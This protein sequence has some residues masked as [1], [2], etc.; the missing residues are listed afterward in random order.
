M[1]IRTVTRQS[2]SPRNPGRPAKGS[3]AGRS[4]G[5]SVDATTAG[6]CASVW[7]PSAL[8]ATPSLTLG[9]GAARCLGLLRD[10]L[11]LGLFLLQAL[12]LLLCCKPCLSHVPHPGQSLHRL[13][14][15]RR[16]HKCEPRH[17][18]GAGACSLCLLDQ[19][20]RRFCQSCPAKG[21][22]A[23]QLGS[24]AARLGRA[25]ESEAR[26]F[27]SHRLRTWHVPRLSRR[28]DL[29]GLARSVSPANFSTLSAWL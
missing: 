3:D 2:G 19:A 26:L 5:G 22:D 18:V 20:S 25:G 15:L 9:F 16:A 28:L 17:I 11:T 8:V 1:I 27:I 29:P 6:G 10:A 13:A 23:G 24:K 12:C 4:P 21:C 14:V 7:P